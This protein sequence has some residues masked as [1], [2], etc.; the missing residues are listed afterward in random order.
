MNNFANAVKDMATLGLTENGAV[1][2]TTTGSAV[3]DLF[4]LG[5]AY[6]TRSDD[7]CIFLFKKA[8]EE[9]EKYALKC[10]FYIRDSMEGQGERRFF[11]VCMKWL[12]Q[13]HPDAV[14]RNM[15]YIPELGGRWDDL[16]V[17]VDTPCQDEA[18]RLMKVQLADD[19]TSEYPSLLAKW[20]KSL[21]T[22]S[23]QS[24]ALAERTRRYLGMTAKQYRKTLSTLRARINVLERLMSA[25]EW[26]KIEYDKIPSRAGF[27][28]RQAF[29][30][31][32]VER[33]QAGVAT[34]EEFAKDENTK[35]NAKVLYPYECV[36]EAKKAMN[37]SAQD[38]D[39][40]MVNKYWDNLKDYFNGASFNGITMV[41]VSGSMYGYEAS[42]P[43][44][45]AVS[46]GMYCAEKAKGPYA[47]HFLT[48]S[49]RPQFVK[50][51]GIDFCDKV[52]RMTSAEWG[53]N[54]NVESA[55]DL[56]LKIAIENH[57]T[58]DEIPKSLLIVSDQ[59]FDY[60]RTSRGYGSSSDTLMEKISIKWEEYGYHCPNLIFWNCQARQ[61]NIPMK[62]KDG[63]TFVSGFSPVIF[64]MV[65]QGKSAQ[66]LMYDKLDNKRYEV[67][68]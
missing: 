58:Q 67:I 43:I 13:T 8:F 61:D 37:R 21:N 10:L 36:A 32:D 16:Y 48:F 20:L 17:F 14:K 46:L 26:D 5:S 56:L 11:R 63:I 29:A 22:S 57:C 19:I 1:T 68:H 41:D 30:R 4:A 24:R 23:A 49:A 27:L 53:M 38:T 51:E 9:D 25:N 47:G 40:L 12:A 64:E 50:V 55:F 6:R 3:Y 62:D 15:A 65:M 28:Y 59:E 34:Y 42:A 18:F 31:H 44:N 2:R 33:K 60:C 66:D 39:R 7:D 52:R 35:V 45:V 54:T